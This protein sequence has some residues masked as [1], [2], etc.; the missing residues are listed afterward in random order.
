M[1]R[2]IVAH[3]GSGAGARSGYERGVHPERVARVGRRL[4]VALV[5][6]AVP[7]LAAVVTVALARG[8]VD[9]SLLAWMDAAVATNVTAGTGL[10]WAF[11]V[12]ALTAVAGVAVYGFALVVEASFDVD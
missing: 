4:A 8:A 1:S 5:G 3:S 12:A 11:H 9:G 6:A 7:A 2:I 10:P